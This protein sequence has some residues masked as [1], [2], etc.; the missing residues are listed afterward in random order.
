MIHFLIHV[1]KLR[2]IDLVVSGNYYLSNENPDRRETERRKLRGNIS[3][4]SNSLDYNTSLAYAQE[5]KSYLDKTYLASEL[6]SK[7]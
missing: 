7:K 2:A 1:Q 6:Q 3:Q 5:V 4:P